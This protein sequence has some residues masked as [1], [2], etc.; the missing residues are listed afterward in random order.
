[1]A[2]KPFSNEELNFLKF[3][4]IIFDEFP[5]AIRQAFATMWDNKVGVLPGYQLWDDSAAVRNMFLMAEGAKTDIPTNSSINCW[6]CTTLFKATI[7][8]K[9]FALPGSKRT[10]AESYIKGRKLKPSPFHLTIISPSGNQD[11]TLALA[12]DQ[13]RLL[14][15]RLCHSAE[16]KM[17]KLSFDHC[18]NLAKDA[19]AALGVN[20]TSIDVIGRLT[21]SDFPTKKVDK[22]NKSIQKGLKARNLFLQ[23]EVIDKFVDLEDLVNQ[24]SETV[25]EVKDLAKTAPILY[26]QMRIMN[27]QL[28]QARETGN[29]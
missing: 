29:I 26:E 9:T 21:E 20:T 25:R 7:Y 11:E 22:L 23:G 15:N 1:M 6:D 4:A 2:V 10:L 24:L 12:I 16:R 14:R 28:V 18:V 27:S 8:A 19:F 5:K 17:D 13:L 3:A